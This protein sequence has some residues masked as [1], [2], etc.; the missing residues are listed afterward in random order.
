[1]RNIDFL[2]SIWSEQGEGFVCVSAKGDSWKDYSF[3]NDES[4]P[5][6]L[7]GWLERNKDK[8]LYFCPLVFG[9][10]RRIKKNALPTKF[11]WGDIDEG[12]PKAIPPSVLWESSPGRY[13]G[14]WRLPQHVSPERGAELSRRIAYHIGGDRGGWDI[15]QVLRIPGT[16]NYKYKERPIVAL[17]E[18]GDR[19]VRIA[20]LPKSALDKWRAAI[21]RKLLATLEGPASGDRSE[22]LWKLE[23][24]LIELGIPGREVIEIL[25]KTAWNK[26]A[27]RA[28]ED[29][30]FAAELEKIEEEKPAKLRP[31][32][33]FRVE[34][35]F[36]VMAKNTGDPGWLVEGFWGRASHGII[37]GEPKSFKSTLAMDMLHAVAMGKSEFMGARIQ[38]GGPVIIIQNENPDHIMRHRFGLYDRARGRSGSVQ[39][40]DKGLRIRFPKDL[41]MY[42]INQQGFTFDDASHLE[43]VES[44]IDQIRPVAVMLDPLYLMFSGDI[45][46]AKDLSPALQWCLYIK[47]TY[48]CAVI[49]VHH[50]GKG[51][52]GKRG[53]QRMLGSTTLHGWVDSAWYLQVQG[54][55]PIVRLEREFRGAPKPEVVDIHMKI[56]ET[57]YAALW[58]EPGG[59]PVDLGD[60]LGTEPQSLHELARRIGMSEERTKEYLERKINEGSVRKEGARYVSTG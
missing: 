39:K 17:R 55:D 26:F 4:L 46:S 31:E 43:Q 50:Y 38:H 42:F 34:T 35:F 22:M 28:D 37:A 36:D 33:V 16:R 14:L 30:R 24:E 41:P 51:T 11:L 29:E 58:T 23:N 2:T 60:V 10:P 59:L 32:S 19:V 54:S 47:Q 18:F 8:D 9:A 7:E 3:P 48:S 15:T 1:M 52:D 20:D 6:K 27:G 5:E 49:L 56:T 21:P 53:G 44:L 40:G 12:D 13:A 45:N 57:S 25:K